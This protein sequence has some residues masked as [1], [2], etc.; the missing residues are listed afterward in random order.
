MGTLLED[1]RY[2]L[3]MLARNPGFSAVAVLTLALGIGANTVIFSLVD[4]FFLR[5]LPVEHP[6]QLVWMYSM[7]QGHF[8]SL[9]YPDYQDLCRQDSAFS[10][11]IAVSRHMALLNIEG[12]TE[13]VKKDTVSE[14]YFSVLR[15]DAAVG[16]MFA[17]GE[18]WTSYKQPPVVISY[19]LW[20]RRF[21]AD[22][23]IVGKTVV[24]NGRHALVLGVAPEWFGG[25]QRGWA[26]E[27]WFPV[28]GWSS[29][30]D[31]QNRESRD[32]FEMLGRLRPG[33]NMGKVRAEL[34]T[35]AH[36][37]ADAYPASNKGLT[38][39][40]STEA[41]E[42]RH[43]LVP[44]FLA[45]GGVGLI[46]LICCANV[47]GMMLARA[48]ARRREIA[49]R[50]TLGAG[51]GRLVGQLLTE[52]MVLALL[53][54][55][56]GLVLT[57]LL[58]R[59]QQALM[60]PGPFVMRLDFRVDLPVLAYALVISLLAAV[61]SGLTPALQ[62]SRTDLVS[63]LRAEEARAESGRW[64][65]G[66][67]S[68]LVAGQVALSLTLLIGAGLFLKSLL[69]SEG[70]NPGFD[71]SKKM[72]IVNLAASVN[73]RASTQQFF[74]PAV[75]K[76]RSL[77]G[78]K[79]AT[80]AF[81]MLLSGSGGGIQCEVSIP[82]VEPPSGQKAFDIKYNSV[83]RDYF[84]TVGAG[85]LRGRVF[86]VR[87][88]TPTNRSAIINESMAQRFWPNTDPI[89]RHFLVEGSDYQIVGLVQDGR[90]EGIHEPLEPYIYFPFA[91]RPMGEATIMVE[92]AGDPR[93]LVGAVKQEIRSVD[94]DVVFFSIQ[95]LKDLMGWALWPDRMFF[96]L[97]AVLGCLGIFL[98]AVGLYGVVAYLTRRRT[99][100]IGIRMA[101]GARRQDVLALV[102]KQGLRPV[103]IG[104]LVGVG[105]AWAVARVISSQ[106][107]GV[108]PWDPAA[109]LG[110]SVLALV[111][112]LFASYIPARRATKVDPMEALRYE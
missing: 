5:S 103:L 20:K 90:I 7:R 72:L 10:G 29:P 54:A 37:L 74:L 57:A 78:V 84:Q 40:V 60:P 68:L 36:R 81:R 70:I 108:K 8:L 1:L 39:V 109:F 79:K 38:F 98:T 22:P 86:D 9:S 94:K 35:I 59:A 107:Y 11:I 4:G 85:V 24:F 3:R 2:G 100:E 89:G 12:A 18:D 6:D 80:Y 52:G 13:M 102:V 105:A 42:F 111:V 46:L 87:E 95:T 21:G 48:E 65:L 26:T 73:P 91:Q 99:H 58:L 93:A 77:P 96:L 30:Q 56:L 106:L 45:L 83:G 97:L 64:W 69:F 34:D 47:S 76:I 49:V 92:T 51:R 32:D 43:N 31:L 101:L 61:I 44:T 104:I 19:G 23:R 14:N 15:V 28:N 33:V 27:V 55:G 17:A 66:A 25:L 71:T 63:T 50:L 16:R 62:A 112:A 82:G 88:E 41:D 67:R 110:G 53:G 75:E